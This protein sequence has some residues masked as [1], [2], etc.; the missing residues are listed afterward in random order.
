MDLPTPGLLWTRWATLAATLTGIGFPDVWFVDDR[1]AHHD[2]HRGGWARF[3]LLDGARS[4]LFGCHPEH[5]ST[6]HA[7]P[8]IDL[9]T[10]APDWLPWEDLGPRAEAD[11]LGFVVWHEHGRWSRTR[12]RAGVADGLVHVVGAVLSVENTLAEL[13]EIITERGRH[14]L[15]TPAARDDVRAASEHLLAAAVRGEVA[16][17]GLEHLLGRL[18]DPTLDLRAALFAA[19]RGGITAGTRP[20]R[21][22]AG[23]RPPM[24][25]I[26]RLSQSEHDRLIWA[27][28]HEATELDRPAPPDTAELD[29]LT[30]WM[31]Q[32][33]PAGDGVC[34]VLAYAD[35][36]SVS[37]QP[38]EPE[39][40]TRPELSDL[41]RALRRAEGDP[42][43]GRWL[44][45]RVMT[46][47]TEVSVE[48]CYDS[49]PPW[50]P[51]D[52]VSG[53]WRTNLE[54]EMLARGRNWRPSWVRLLDPEIAYRPAG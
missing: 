35:A 13:S 52:G 22:R 20:P 51:D 34:T 1:G 54:A 33:G 23:S 40:L 44:F 48:R 37:V 39:G 9:L 2:D 10:G 47:A 46:A 49:W 6:A 25:R 31:R 29:G 12:Y 8:P 43:Y 19:G 27:A 26:R 16:A 3:G 32:H 4:V 11:E 30:G 53:P 42:R 24:R 28:M 7:D 36:T 38:C 50:W 45:L 41:V 5:S 17:A 18:T 15:R 14:P 21:I